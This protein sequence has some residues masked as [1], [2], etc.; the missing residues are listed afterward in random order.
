MGS[1]SFV[2]GLC[3][4]IFMSG[5]TESRG[6]NSVLCCGTANHCRG[7]L[8]IHYYSGCGNLSSDGFPQLLIMTLVLCRPADLLYQTG[9]VGCKLVQVNV[10]AYL[11]PK[12]P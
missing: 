3:L 1:L 5:A 2:Y 12:E 11:F 8:Y 7:S 6:G 10:C 4:A 9:I